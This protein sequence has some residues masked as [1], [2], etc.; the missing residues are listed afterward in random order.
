MLIRCA[1]LS[2]LREH[3][4]YGYRLKRRF[5]E[6]VGPGWQLNVG[7]VYQS[8][9]SLERAGFVRAAA[10]G[11]PASH[12][13][14]IF[15]ITPKGLRYL[16]RWA[17]RPP[18]APRPVRD[19]ALVWLLVAPCEQYPAL[20][21]RLDQQIVSYDRVLADIP[22]CDG[23][24]PRIRRLALAGTL[25]HLEAHLRWLRL[26]RHVLAGPQTVGARPSH[27]SAAESQRLTAASS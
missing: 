27:G 8:L 25:L 19:D 9:R 10:G 7:Q 1:L 17:Q 6:A 4:D 15:E 5:D 16:G 20:V 22:R 2:L 14:R 23:S 12:P 26:C 13:R 3:A 11:E 18:R 24:A 21:V